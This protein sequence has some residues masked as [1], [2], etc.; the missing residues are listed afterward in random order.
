MP[1]QVIRPLVDSLAY[2]ADVRGRGR[3][4]VLVGDLDALAS[5]L[6]F[7]GGRGR[8]E[9]RGQEQIRARGVAEDVHAVVLRHIV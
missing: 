3:G 7:R 5:L 9:E 6:G 8:G 2:M 4:S 1:R